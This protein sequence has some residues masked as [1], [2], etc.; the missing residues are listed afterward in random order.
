MIYLDHAATTPVLPQAA[1]AAFDAMTDTYGNPSSQH[2]PGLAAAQ[3]LTAARNRL[4]DLT[5]ARAQ[6]V[7]FTSGGTEANNLAIASALRGKPRGRIIT[8]SLEHPSVSQA[9]NS[10]KAKGYDIVVIPPD[11]TGQLN[12]KALSKALTPETV[13]VCCTAVCSVTGAMPPVDDIANAMSLICPSAWLH[14]DAVQALGHVSLPKRPQTLSLSGHKLGAPKGVGAVIARHSARLSPLW[15][16]GSQEN[17]SRPGTENVPGIAALN[18]A[19]QHLPYPTQLTALKEYALEK[20]AV[21][22]QVVIIPPH[23]APHIV[24]FSLPSE[25][26]EVLVRRLSDAGICLSTGS[27]CSKG[28]QESLYADMLLPP[29]VT[30]SALR[31]SLGSGNTTADIDALCQQLTALV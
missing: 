24:A 17:G 4:A 25:P 26:G 14:C 27:A 12:M 1:Q 8:T 6:D 11:K 22:S 10:Y 20:L 18:V 31:L 30:G 19:L 21:I 15:Q 2:A 3:L 9:V 28:K 29:E 16:G 13:L 7:V 5:G 23:T